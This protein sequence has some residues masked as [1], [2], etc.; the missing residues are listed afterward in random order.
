MT[1]QNLIIDCE[2]GEQVYAAVPAPSLEEA[3]AAVAASIDRR[4]DTAFL[5]GFAPASGPLAGK[6]LQTRNVEDRTNWLTSQ[7][8]YSA[9]VAGGLGSASGATFRTADNE[10]ITCTYA[11]GLQTLLAMAEWGKE[12]MGASWALKDAVAAARD[13]TALSAI[14]ME[15]G[16]P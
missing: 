14:D 12:V 8:A 3:K 10:T 16:W 5:A 11:E 9:A 6:V 4:R 1:M 13:L 7:A 2:T 15:A